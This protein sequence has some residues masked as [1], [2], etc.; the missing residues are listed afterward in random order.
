MNI[1]MVLVQLIKYM[2]NFFIQFSQSLSIGNKLKDVL[3]ER[4][5]KMFSFIWSLILS[6]IFILCKSLN[7]H[8]YFLTENGTYQKDFKEVLV[9]TLEVRGREQPVNECKCCEKVESWSLKAR[10][11]TG[12]SWTIN[13]SCMCKQFFTLPHCR[14]LLLL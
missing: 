10:L 5:L 12:K 6:L 4:I 1:L 7:W 14:G 2:C 13:A 11:W 3:L 8:V 9:H